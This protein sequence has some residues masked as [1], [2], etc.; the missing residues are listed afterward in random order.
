MYLLLIVL[1]VVLFAVF[2]FSPA[3]G[4]ESV[5]VVDQLNGQTV[6]TFDFATNT[7][8]ISP[9]Y[10]NMVTV[11]P[12]GDKYTFTIERDRDL[13]K[14]WQNVVE[15]STKQGDQYAK[16]IDANCPTHDCIN[17]F[18]PIVQND[19]AIVCSPHRLK[20]VSTTSNQGGIII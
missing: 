15:I 12:N 1:V 20:I 8:S 2:V 10:S 19:Q 17:L 3:K 11:V 14:V 9:Q 13:G 5:K 4:L 18:N 16:M 6:F 7:Y